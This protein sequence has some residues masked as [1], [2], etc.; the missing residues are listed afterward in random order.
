[1]ILFVPKPLCCKYIRELYNYMNDAYH[2]ILITMRTIT[3]LFRCH[4]ISEVME[5]YLKSDVIYIMFQFNNVWFCNQI[6]IYLR[7][8]FQIS[9]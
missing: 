4:E 5:M 1:M 2:A 8:V 6:D 3:I 7:V 9:Q